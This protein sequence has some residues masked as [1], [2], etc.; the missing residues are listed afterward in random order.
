MLLKI[1]IHEYRHTNI[2]KIY[3]MMR[4]QLEVMAKGYYA[5]NNDFFFLSIDSLWYHDTLWAL[6]HSGW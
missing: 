3:Y 6:M 2:V 4:P 1:F 5:Y